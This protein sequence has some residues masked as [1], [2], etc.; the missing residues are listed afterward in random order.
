M[1]GG[2]QLAVLALATTTLAASGCGSSA[3]PLTRAELTA[4]ADAIC[5]TVTTR[6]AK[7]TIRTQQDI[8]RVAGELAAFEQ[9][10]LTNLSKLVPPAT[11]ADDWKQFVAGAQTL[12]ENT[13][14]IG[15]YAKANNLKASK[16]LIT[17]SQATQRQMTAVA[18]R[19]GLKSCEQVP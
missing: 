18:K 14:K 9:V 19:D 13:S 8:A 12:A 11:L 15:E 10:A 16:S 1:G 17:S 6:L 3:K 7:N 4:K 2:R 5:K